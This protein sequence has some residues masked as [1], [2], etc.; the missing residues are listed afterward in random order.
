MKEVLDELKNLL[1][2]EQCDTVTCEKTSQDQ[3]RMLFKYV[4]GWGNNGKDKLF[5]AL[6]KTNEQVIDGIE[7]Q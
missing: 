5:E 2:N 1:T 4:R 7:G 6:K 3:M